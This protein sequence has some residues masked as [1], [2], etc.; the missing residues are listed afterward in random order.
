MS[1]LINQVVKNARNQQADF[2]QR[3]SAI[4]RVC[5]EE[6]T[7]SGTGTADIY[8]TLDND[9]GY[10]SEMKFKLVLGDTGGAAPSP[11]GTIISYLGNGTWK[12]PDEFIAAFPAGAAVDT[13]NAYGAQCWDYANAFWRGQV[14]RDLKT[15]S[16][17]TA[18]DCWNESRVYNAGSEFDL[19]TSYSQVQK[20]DWIVWGAS[21]YSYTGHIAMALGPVQGGMVQCIGQNQPGGLPYPGGGTNICIANLS[22]N[23]FL[24][25]FRYK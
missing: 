8:L 20:G 4:V 18:A 7:S 22:I 21:S 11:G 25:A 2:S 17:G 14:N 10:I 5:G 3:R 16:H 24:G 9:M 1:D 13:D 12:T 6:H 15:G 19:I 23:G